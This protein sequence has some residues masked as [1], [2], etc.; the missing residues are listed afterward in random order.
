MLERAVTGILKRIDKFVKL[1]DTVEREISEILR[2]RR[3][4]RAVMSLVLT[5]RENVDG[6]PGWRRVHVLSSRLQRIQ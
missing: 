1:S 6:I 2:F 3:V 5:D 4:E